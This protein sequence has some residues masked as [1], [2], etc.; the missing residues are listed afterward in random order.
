MPES[1]SKT[2]KAPPETISLKKDDYL[3]RENEAG[4]KMFYI[5]S[6]TL[7]VLKIRGGMEHEIGDIFAGEIVGE[8]SFLD[9]KTRSASVKASSDC[10]VVVIHAEKF[11][12]Q[13][14]DLPI[15]F[16][17]LINTILDRLRRANSRIR[18]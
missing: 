8:I 12:K 17:A 1:K 2:A 10:E 15:W 9:N 16:R 7:K 14:Q 3:V 5:Q 11:E 13:T 4:N 18:I 6:G